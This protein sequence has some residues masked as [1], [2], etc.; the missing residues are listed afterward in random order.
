MSRK[1]KSQAR[2]QDRKKLRELIALH[3]ARTV[4]GCEPVFIG[5]QSRAALKG[6]TFG[7][8]IRDAKGKFRSNIIWIE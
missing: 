6:R 7:Y 5:Q 4:P 1:R 2:K 3:V 8:R